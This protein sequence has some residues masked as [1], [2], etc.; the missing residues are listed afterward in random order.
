[1]VVNRAQVSVH[2]YL[3]Q[4][5][6]RSFTVADRA[7]VFVFLL[8]HDVQLV[9]RVFPRRVKNALRPARFHLQFPFQ[10][11]AQTLKSSKLHLHIMAKMRVA[12]YLERL[13]TVNQGSGADLSAV[14]R[15]TLIAPSE[16][17]W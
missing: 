3:Q 6:S 15:H 11:R 13:G 12:E 5:D 9:S 1:M 16:S 17:M 2:G 14:T 10:F 8:M 4:A 7:F